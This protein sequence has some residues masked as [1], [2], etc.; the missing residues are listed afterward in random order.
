V[1]L[2]AA[3]APSAPDPAGE[4]A[5]FPRPLTGFKGPTSKGKRRRGKGSVKGNPRPGLGK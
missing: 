3:G 4:L 5:A 1:N 2:P